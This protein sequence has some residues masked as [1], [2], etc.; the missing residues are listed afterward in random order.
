M[1]ENLRSLPHAKQTSGHVTV[2]VYQQVRATT[3]TKEPNALHQ[4]A[5][6]SIDD[7]EQ[8]HLLHVGLRQRCCKQT[9]VHCPIYQ[10]SAAHQVWVL[11][12]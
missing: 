10:H 3:L 11:W 8:L 5:C 2:R 1:R 6:V 4:D 7:Q 9:A 12:L